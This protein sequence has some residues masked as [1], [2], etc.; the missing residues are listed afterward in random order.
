MV[1]SRSVSTMLAKR[2]ITRL[3][4]ERFDQHIVLFVYLVHEG[5]HRDNP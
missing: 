1:R 5:E 3:R 4:E 2:M